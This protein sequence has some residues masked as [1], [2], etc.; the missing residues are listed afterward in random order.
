MNISEKVL[1]TLEYDKVMRSVSEYAVLGV[2]KEKIKNSVPENDFLSAE[3]SLDTTAEADALLYKYAV[4]G[5]DFFD[6]ITDELDRAKKGAT[7]SCSE[8]LRVM[9][10][11]RSSRLSKGAITVIDDEKIVYLRRIAEQIFTEHYIENDIASKIVSD[12]QVSDNASETLYQIRRKIKKINDSI[13]EKLASY[14][15]GNKMKYLQEN[16]ITMRG[17]RYV[18]PVKNEYRS[19]IKGLVHDQSSTGATVFI[20]PEA[21]LDL[22]NDLRT[23][24][25]EEN[26]EV[27]K[28]LYDLSR[29]VGS[30]ADALALNID[31]LASLDIAF[32]KAEYA[33][34]TRS[35]RPGF[36]ENGFINIVRGRH[37][38]I[39]ADKVVPLD[40]RFGKDNRFL[41]ITGPNTGGKTVTLKLVGLFTLMAMSGLFVPAKDGTSLSFFDKI[42]AD[43]GDEQS[44]EQSLSTFSSHIKNIINITENAD[45]RS[46][47]LIDEIGAGTDPDEGSALAQAVIETLLNL[48]SR[49]IITTHYSRL[50]EYAYA[51]DGIENASMDFDSETFAPLYKL[52]I[53]VPGS[54][55][56]IEI[57]KRLGLSGEIIDQ[58]YSLLTENKISFEN[59]LREAEKSRQEAE[60]YKAEYS[61]LTEEAIRE[62]EA[63]KTERA[64]LEQDKQR[65]IAG[66]KSEA[67][68]L[69]NEREE[70]AD[71]LIDE[72]KQLLKKQDLS[73]GDLIVARTL[74]NKIADSKYNLGEEDY[75][76]L[77]MKPVD[78]SSLKEGD[79]VYVSSLSSVGTVCRVSPRKGEVEVMSGSV[80]L[81]V[82]A[83]KLFTVK[84][85]EQKTKSSLKKSSSVSVKR[86]AGAF[87]EVKTEINVIG[88]NVDEALINV[89]QF[90]DSCVVN[91][92]EEC[93]IVHGKG[94]HILGKAI[95]DY[96]KKQ[97]FVK[98]YRYGVYGEGEKG[99]TIVKFK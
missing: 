89:E 88:Q 66:A 3:I 42:F 55:N 90:L 73:S 28:I 4:S 80:R 40:V 17:D 91:N 87:N 35:L 86:S 82:K 11:L 68:Q 6:E 43:I 46:L 19:Q 2:S 58:A 26:A 95:Q 5:V 54:S 48:S 9:R 92:V 12:D 81:N 23:A 71:E 70:Y 29:Q 93:R 59:V 1:L 7:L 37:P 15:R 27:E 94:L 74:K 32:A 97:P 24:I 16:I 41:L 57:S 96:L 78:L 69:V 18:I 53:G 34:K 38:L 36:N 99:V 52:N 22:N 14:V 61:R 76:D 65:F 56:A 25:A 39:D 79:E 44:I 13:R 47:V 98:E 72:I 62:S 8:L 77:P 45:E 31:L 60:K 51:R 63:V 49:G 21:V 85:T 20:E 84:K 10:L 75:S 83:D 30:M 67:R 33:Y 64:K 50:K